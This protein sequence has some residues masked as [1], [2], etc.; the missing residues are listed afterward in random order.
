MSEVIGP[1]LLSRTNPCPISN[2]NIYE[3]VQGKALGPESRF[4][5]SFQ[6]KVMSRSILKAGLS[7]SLRFT[8]SLPGGPGLVSP[9][10]PASVSLS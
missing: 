6:S 2:F 5:P 1:G 9:L 10:L 8:I 4:R 3:Q 7:S